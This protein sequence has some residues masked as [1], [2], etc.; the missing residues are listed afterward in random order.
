MR[1]R[2]INAVYGQWILYLHDINY[3][4]VALCIAIVYIASVLIRRNL[5]MLFTFIQ[6]IRKNLLA[7][8]LVS[9]FLVLYISIFDDAKGYQIQKLES[10][11]QR[12]VFSVGFWSTHDAWV[13]CATQLGYPIH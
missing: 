7:V 10:R 1:H 6:F 2:T 8:A 13:E 4:N 12:S 11:F 5:A 3:L 9:L